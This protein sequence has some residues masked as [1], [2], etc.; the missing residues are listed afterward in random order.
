MQRYAGEAERGGDVAADGRA[1]LADAGGE[2][3][4]VDAVEDAGHRAD[5]A[6]QAPDEAVV[7]EA[8]A[9]VSRL[10]GRQHLAQIGRHFGD[11]EEARAA[12]ERRAQLVGADAAVGL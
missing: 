3:E 1:M 11:A 12:D 9:R 5:G 10:R 6:A 7:G 4:R 8:R 2:H